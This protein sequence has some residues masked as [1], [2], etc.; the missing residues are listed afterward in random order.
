MLTPRKRNRQGIRVPR[1]DI[2][3]P[4]GSFRDFQVS[5][6]LTIFS[7]F[8][9]SRS[10]RTRTYPEVLQKGSQVKDAGSRNTHGK[11]C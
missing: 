1:M 7:A 3:D 9:R 4:D 2:E 8:R 6:Y 11:M 5:D 10:N